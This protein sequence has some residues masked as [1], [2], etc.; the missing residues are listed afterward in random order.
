MRYDWF[1]LLIFRIT[2]KLYFTGRLNRCYR[3]VRK[4]NALWSIAL[5]WGFQHN[6]YIPRVGRSTRMHCIYQNHDNFYYSGLSNVDC[7]EW[8]I[9]ITKTQSKKGADPLPS[10]QPNGQGSL[11]TFLASLR[12]SMLL[13]VSPR[14]ISILASFGLR[15]E[16]IAMKKKYIYTW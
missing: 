13:Y 4:C 11:F 8:L 12:F 7:L 10:P 3:N 16:N 15:N 6:G 9:S 14:A 2:L 5:P 1:P